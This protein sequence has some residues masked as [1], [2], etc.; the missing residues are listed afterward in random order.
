MLKLYQR[1]G[2]PYCHKVRE[3]LTDLGLSYLAVNV[4][5]EREQR[6]EVFE[7]SG[8]YLIPVFVDGDQVV[9]D[10]ERIIEYLEAK[11]GR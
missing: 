11:H 2:C 6:A 1:E 5:Q 7:V 8:Q 3:K 10:S 4:P 9:T